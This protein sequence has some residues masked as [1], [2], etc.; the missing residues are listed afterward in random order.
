MYLII[1]ILLVLVLGSIIYYQDKTIK[2]FKK[3]VMNLNLEISRF[4]L[5]SPSSDK[6]RLSLEPIINGIKNLAP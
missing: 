3:D 6:M 4:I 5:E 1:I 2:K